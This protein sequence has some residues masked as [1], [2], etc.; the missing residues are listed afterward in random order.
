MI[1][2]IAHKETGGLYGARAEIAAVAPLL[3]NAMSGILL[4]HAS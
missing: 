1:I 4:L 2:R 3:R